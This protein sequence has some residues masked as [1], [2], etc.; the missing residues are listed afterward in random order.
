MKKTKRLI[1]IFIVIALFICLGVCIFNRIYI[2]TSDTLSPTYAPSVNFLHTG[3]WFYVYDNTLYFYESHYFLSIMYV[4]NNIV[5]KFADVGIKN[6]DGFCILDENTAIIWSNWYDPPKTTIYS[7]NKSGDKAVKLW[8]GYCVGCFDN[9]VYYAKD[10]TLYSS[11]IGQSEPDTVTFFST[12]LAHDNYGITY[13][14]GDNVYQLLYEDPQRPKLLFTGENP[15]KYSEKVLYDNIVENINAGLYTSDY[16]LSYSFDSIEMFIYETREKKKI[17]TPDGG[18]ANVSMSIVA[19]GNKLYVSRQCIDFK[20]YRV[21]NKKINGTYIYDIT[22]DTWTKL[23]DKTYTVL[24][25]FDENYLYGYDELSLFPR[26]VRIKV[27]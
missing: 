18:A 19:N 10:N 5:H 22:E 9:K 15:W 17:Y 1:K 16:A 4:K 20:Y 8:D 26:V 6:I 13:R 12:L 24:A 21:K 11:K 14:V 25:Q 7:L 2:P 27:D 23:S 3:N